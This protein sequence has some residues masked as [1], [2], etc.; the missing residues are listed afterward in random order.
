MR[1]MWKLFFYQGEFILETLKT[2]LCIPEQVSRLESRGLIID[3]QNF[4]E[5]FLEKV[6][7]YRL[8]G[9]L[10]DFKNQDTGRYDN[11]VSFSQIS[12][13]YAFDAKF[14]RLLLY[15]LED[16]EE[17]LKT[18]FSYTLSS[19]YPT[20]S[21]IYLDETIYS[22]I[23]SL[24]K[25]KK[26][27]E[28]AKDKNREL[29]FVKH[30]FQKYDGQLPI[31]VAVEIMTMGNI[32][33]LFRA[34]RTTFKKEIA[35]K[36]HTGPRQLENWI[37]NLTFTRNHLAHYMRVYNYRFGRIPKSCENHPISGIYKGKIFDQI[38]LMSFMF[39]NPEEWN[40]YVLNEM[41]S[42][43]RQYRDTI[44]L[45]NIGFPKNWRQILTT[46]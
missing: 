26:L 13:I 25:F 10:S 18:R 46:V 22:D 5:S 38:A 9:Y 29:P 14:T 28:L 4:A 31:W 11:H 35:K 32:N 42:L 6:N 43:F 21:L 23:E 8:S 20:N 15:I 2:H 16:I 41:A 27:F 36:Y 39:S 1:T 44:L 12:R 3:N 17:T 19:N 7:Y 24:Y 40:S 34:L 45:S 30:H 33:S 37:E